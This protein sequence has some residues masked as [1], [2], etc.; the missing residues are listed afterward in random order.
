MSLD[1]PHGQ[2]EDAGGYAK[3]LPPEFYQKEQEILRKHTKDADVVITSALIPGRR[4]P[5]L[6]TEEMLREMKPGSV[7]VDLAVEQKGNCTF[8]EPGNVVTHHEV[9]IIGTLNLPSRVPIHASQLYAKNVLN[10]L[11]HLSPDGKS[12]RSDRNDEI[13]KG[14]LITLNGEIVHPAVKETAKSKAIAQ[15]V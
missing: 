10:F 7:I 2:A 4:A 15:G 8:S 14:A 1:V 3:E 11:N 9:T 6:I 13:I 5:I 12:I